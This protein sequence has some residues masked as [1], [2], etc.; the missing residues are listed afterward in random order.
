MIIIVLQKKPCLFFEVLLV[1]II[2]FAEQLLP[3]YENF[4]LNL[5]SISHLFFLER[6][7]FQ[8]H[9]VYIL[10]DVHASLVARLL[11][12]FFSH[13]LSYSEIASLYSWSFRP[14]ALYQHPD[15]LVLKAVD[16]LQ[17]IRLSHDCD[18][19]L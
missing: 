1:V 6:S 10:L 13:S 11:S 7:L 19:R 2:Q 9:K 3:S 8:N 17:C 15:H 16:I 14:D 4:D 5:I 12:G 18:L